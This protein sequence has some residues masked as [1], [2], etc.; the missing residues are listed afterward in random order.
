MIHELVTAAFWFSIAT[1]NQV[2]A[3]LELDPAEAQ[4]ARQG[5]AYASAEE[6][7][8]ALVNAE[9]Q[10]GADILQMLI[11][12]QG[13]QEVIVYRGDF[14]GEDMRAIA[15]L[16][17]GGC[18]FQTKLD[19]TDWRGADLSGTDF[20]GA[21]ADGA[22]FNGA[23]LEDARI[24]G[25]SLKEADFTGAK[26]ARS[27]FI[28]AFGSLNLSNTN[29]TRADLTEASF[30]CGIEVYAWCFDSYTA[31]F[32]EAELARAELSTLG[33]W[34]EGNFDCARLDDTRISPR[35]IPHLAA[36]SLVGPI[37]LQSQNWWQ[38]E[39][40][41]RP[42]T[43]TVS[44]QEFRALVVASRSAKRD[45]PSF[46]CTKAGN[47]AER[48]ICGEYNSHLRMKD[49][50]M[51]ALYGEVR[52]AGKV[53][54]QSQRQWI[55]SRNRC[56]DEECLAASYDRR[57][58]ILFA[59]RGD[60]LILAPD[61]SVTYYNETLPL[62]DELRDTPLYRRILPVLKDAASQSI[63]L[64]GMEDGSVSAE[65]DAL[66]ANAHICSM[67]V[68][69]A[70]FDPANGWHS[71]TL[72]DGTRVPLFRVWGDR[73]LLRYSGNLGDTPEEA[74]D[75]ISCGARASFIDGR[76]LD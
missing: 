49:R 19:K 1:S 38:A 31:Q 27:R 55:Q 35:S 9:G 56:A 37:I 17:R 64:T 5:C 70:T 13:A 59:A 61:Q 63:T 48:T 39:G 25:M 15:P 74:W 18:F 69:D 46:D 71:G 21:S 68:Y 16:V 33:I 23:T 11:E 4:M 32:G 45:V 6:R 62:A 2:E 20:A 8:A 60:R 10:T 66:G 24:V 67:G 50:D 72:E 76:R 41:E 44:P 65:G 47:Y 34:L 53:T 40:D 26:L 75:F 28:G 58:D 36:A 7:D 51:A 52:G 54:T 22:N 43:A 42:P 12:K 57:M 3:K 14:S 30:A 29:F 73:L